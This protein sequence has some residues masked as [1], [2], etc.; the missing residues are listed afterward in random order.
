MLAALTG[1]FHDPVGA[2]PAVPTDVGAPPADRDEHPA[3]RAGF[4]WIAGRW[5]RSGEKWVWLDG[6]YQRTHPNYRWEQGHWIHVPTPTDDPKPANTQWATSVRAFST[7]YSTDGWSAQQVIGPPDV[8]PQAGDMPKA[9]ASQQPDAPGEFIEVAY[10]RPIRVSAVEV[11]E[12][13]N[14][15]AISQIDLITATRTLSYAPAG[16]SDEP[17]TLHVPCTSEPVIAVR[18]TLDSVAVPGWNEID[19]IGLVP[20]P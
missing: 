17:L 12:T 13:F 15:G 6:Y 19:A 16:S 4:E 8:F 3:P 10:A 20:C 5:A 11:Y 14:P 9:W 18:V 2:S 7:Q 1:C